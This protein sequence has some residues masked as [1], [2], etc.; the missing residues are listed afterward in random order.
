MLP[1]RSQH[2]AC[3]QEELVDSPR[4]A[5]SPGTEAGQ[6]GTECI[7]INMH[8]HG[9]MSTTSDMS[10]GAEIVTDPQSGRRQ[11][12]RL[13]MRRA[14]T[15][16]CPHRP[17]RARQTRRHAWQQLR[18]VAV[19][20]WQRPQQSV[21]VSAS[22]AAKARRAAAKAAKAAKKV[23]KAAKVK[24]EAVKAVKSRPS[25]WRSRRASRKGK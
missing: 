24:E 23:K 12:H 5:I 18:R 2:V 14:R 6:N 20:Q 21:L 4:R 3:C 9:P 11:C 15:P 19:Q 7:C 10:M 17:P 22:L 13:R 1:C 25:S 8:A 16:T